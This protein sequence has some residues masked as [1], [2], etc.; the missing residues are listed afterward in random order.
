MWFSSWRLCWVHMHT[1][2][3]SSSG[4]RSLYCETRWSDGAH[5]RSGQEYTWWRSVC[6]WRKKIFTTTH[7]RPSFFVKKLNSSFLQICLSHMH[8]LQTDEKALC[9]AISLECRATSRRWGG[10][11]R[12][13]RSSATVA[14]Q[15]Y[16]SRDYEPM[17]MWSGSYSRRHNA[18]VFVK[19]RRRRQGPGEYGMSKQETGREVG[20]G[21]R[22]DLASTVCC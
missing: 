12:V 1:L 18:Y 13:L 11:N 8:T 22:R 19:E 9:S 16:R 10:A 4:T 15:P 3:L 7:N 17:E 5:Y 21:I 6:M 20:Q 14:Y 2:C